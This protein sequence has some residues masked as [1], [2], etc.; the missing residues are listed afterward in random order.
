MTDQTI[1]YSEESVSGAFEYDLTN[2]GEQISIFISGLSAGTISVSYLEGTNAYLLKAYTTDADDIIT[3]SSRKVR[4]SG[5]GVT[6]DYL[7]IAS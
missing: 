7:S 3:V 2:T 5:V 1:P 4:V 6:A